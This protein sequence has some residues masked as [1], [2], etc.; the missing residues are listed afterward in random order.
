M[1]LALPASS[2]FF[3]YAPRI[4]LRVDDVVCKSER[5]GVDEP[6]VGRFH[7]IVSAAGRDLEGEEMS[8]DG[9]DWSYF[10]KRGVFNWE[11]Q[12]GPDNILGYPVDG[13]LE[14]TVDEEGNPATSVMG[15]LVLD[16]KKAYETWETM[17]AL[18]KA[19]N[20]RQV[21]FSV[22]G[23]VLKRDP[24]NSKKIT[25]AW[26]RAVAICAHPMRSTA[27]VLSI[28]KSMDALRIELMVKGEIGYQ[29]A[30]GMGTGNCA[31]LM[32]QSIDRKLAN[33][34]PLSDKAWRMAVKGYWPHL[35][36]N[37]VEYMA[38][39]FQ[40]DYEARRKKNKV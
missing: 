17:C 25:K 14:R 6:N 8:Q 34:T 3:A 19:G 4:T 24:R 37:T 5:P 36:D 26:V 27:R 11:H 9:L 30:P 31:P 23:P 16:K 12:P 29:S 1:T 22:E 35:D 21:G 18:Q 10:M 39:A 28:A 38:K 15:E 7:A 20:K 13:S 40:Y 2:E 32:G 33:L